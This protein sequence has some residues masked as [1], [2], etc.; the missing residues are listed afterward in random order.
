[1]RYEQL[2]PLFFG[3][4]SHRRQENMDVLRVTLHTYTVPN[5]NKGGHQRCKGD[6]QR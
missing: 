4:R 1:M 3:G 5:G 2:A 6:R